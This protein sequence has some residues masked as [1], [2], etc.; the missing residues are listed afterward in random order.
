[1]IPSNVTLR[2][3]RF[4]STQVLSTLI[5]FFS[6]SGTLAIA[7]RSGHVP[8]EAPRRDERQRRDRDADDE[9]SRGEVGELD[10]AVIG[11]LDTTVELEAAAQALYERLDKLMVEDDGKRL[12]MDEE[13]VRAFARINSSQRIA[14]HTITTQKKFLSRLHR[15][16]QV[17]LD[18]DVVVGWEP[19]DR[20][21]KKVAD[22]T[23][24]AKKA[25]EA[26]NRQRTWI[27]TTLAELPNAVDIS[28]APTL[29]ETIEARDTE[30]FLK[31]IAEYNAGA[32]A[33]LE[34][35]WA[36]FWEAGHTATVE[37]AKIDA[38]QKLAHERAKNELA[39]Q[40][41]K[42]K[43][44]EADA[45][46]AKLKNNMKIELDRRTAAE[47]ERLAE[48]KIAYEKKL[49]EVERRE[50]QGEADRYAGDA[51]AKIEHDKTKGDAD[52]LKKKAQ[53]QTEEV[54]RL[55]KPFTT[56]G[57]MR[58]NQRGET[59]DKKPHSLSGL[60]S[61][62]AL[63]PTMQGVK[64]LYNLATTKKDKVRPRWGK[65]KRWKNLNQSTKEKAKKAQKYLLELGEALVELGMLAP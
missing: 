56:P 57:F 60:R 63:E 58:A 13:T 23:K 31:E 55:L 28:A 45:E 24:W 61:L 8:K 22:K 1:V 62:G 26:V 50:R 44:A 36:A 47:A 43:L 64:K 14:I 17:E 16:L 18:E 21:D 35:S 12:A 11:A 20:Q 34:D 5:L 32:D 10:A 19:S 39:E 30:L 33:A 54:R 9:L 48:A 4:N 49:A 15:K 41:S 37:R 65:A 6:F 53:A 40:E 59:Y 27:R 29:G 46:I 51:I 3:C 52:H 7:Q 38:D 2:F 25:L 42:R